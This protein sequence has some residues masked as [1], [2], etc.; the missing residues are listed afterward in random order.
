MPI[1][2]FCCQENARDGQHCGKFS[3]ENRTLY[4]IAHTTLHVK[5]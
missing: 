5:Q 2:L 1:F 3:I 4:D